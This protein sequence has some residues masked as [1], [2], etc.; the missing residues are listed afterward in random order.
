[1]P[2][3]SS[4]TSGTRWADRL[5]MLNALIC[6]VHCLALPLL[7]TIGSF[8][9]LL[10]ESIWLDLVF[11]AISYFAVW[12][13]AR[14]SPAY[15]PTIRWLWLWASIFAISLLIGHSGYPFFEYFSYFASVM[16][17]WTHFKRYRE[18]GC[19]NDGAPIAKID[20][21][22]SGQKAAHDAF[23]EKEQVLS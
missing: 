5:G 17:A 2:V 10:L 4:S 18:T 7:A 20:Y 15:T 23:R 9:H 13:V 14:K 11:I 6:L 21:R 12:R 8:S 16:L 3:S 22:T 1:M 19:S